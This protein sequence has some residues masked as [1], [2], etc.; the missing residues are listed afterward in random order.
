M[1]DHV[2]RRPTVAARD[3]PPHAGRGGPG[4]AVVAPRRPQG[5]PRIRAHRTSL[6]DA[7]PGPPSRTT[8]GSS[9]CTSFAFRA[10]GDSATA[11]RGE[12][13]AGRPMPQTLWTP[14]RA[15]GQP[16]ARV[17][18]GFCTRP[19]MWCPTL[20]EVLRTFHDALRP[21]SMVGKTGRQ[22]W[23]R[24]TRSRLDTGWRRFV[25]HGS[26]PWR[27]PPTS[28]VGRV[29][30]S[31]TSK[32]GRAALPIEDINGLAAAFAVSP[33]VIEC[34]VPIPEVNDAAPAG[35]L[36]FLHEDDVAGITRRTLLGGM[37]GAAAAPLAA[38]FE[39][40]V[41]AGDQPSVVGQH[42]IEEL[43]FVTAQYGS[44]CWR[45]SAPFF[46]RRVAA[47]QAHLAELLGTARGTAARRLKVLLAQT[48]VFGSLAAYREH[49][50]EPHAM[51][52]GSR[53]TWPPTPTTRP[54][55]PWCWASEG[56]SSDQS[57]RASAS[58]PEMRWI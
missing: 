44:W 26:S 25:T 47:H 23:T 57:V 43:E 54:L 22:R 2:A 31:T 48:A 39:S 17:G 50:F 42:T 36:G 35:A 38:S 16:L 52:R 24:S 51:R 56:H 6:P 9:P 58:E 18:A 1:P 40:L 10:A 7:P 37:A 34:I 21:P 13:H 5:A 15:A 19:V 14:R 20:G 41:A 27:R 49:H 4:R 53:R 55:L 28:L 3:G 29:D 12:W 33:A 11:R 45:L 32:P 30:G 46:L 8:S